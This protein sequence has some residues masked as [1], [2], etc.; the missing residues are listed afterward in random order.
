[1][2][3][4]AGKGGVRTL[5]TPVARDP[6]ITVQRLVEQGDRID[7]GNI[8]RKL[9]LRQRAVGGVVEVVQICVTFGDLNDSRAGIVNPS[10]RPNPNRV[11]LAALQVRVVVRDRI[12]VGRAGA[13]DAVTPGDLARPIV[14][15]VRG[16]VLTVLR[17]PQQAVRVVG[18]GRRDR[19]DRG[20]LVAVGVVGEAE[21]AGTI[22]SSL[23][24]HPT[25][26]QIGER[27]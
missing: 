17:R 27:E 20:Q 8:V 16:P 18:I 21:R 12:L 15:V 7:G 22:P 19:A 23:I 3:D 6:K 14:C 4:I 26:G 9:L 1:M 11:G 2:P 5:S 10:R 13:R 25:I 24:R